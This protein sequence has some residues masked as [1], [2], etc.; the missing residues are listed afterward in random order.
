MPPLPPPTPGKR[1]PRPSLLSLSAHGLRLGEHATRRGASSGP[2]ARLQVPRPPPMLLSAAPR[3]GGESGFRMARCPAT[4]TVPRSG[5]A[6]VTIEKEFALA[7][8]EPAGSPCA[9]RPPTATQGSRHTLRAHPAS[10][11]PGD[12]F[13]SVFVFFLCCLLQ[14]SFSKTSW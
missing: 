8:S 10:Q 7:N 6:H 3:T 14:L 13:P 1:L 12:G 4:P 2:D 9:R 11:K 5:P